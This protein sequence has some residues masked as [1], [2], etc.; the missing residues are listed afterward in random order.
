MNLSKGE[1]N[2]QL[3]QPLNTA[4][5]HMWKKLDPR[6]ASTCTT[7]WQLLPR[8]EWRATFFW[9]VLFHPF[10]T[11]ALRVKW[12]ENPSQSHPEFPHCCCADS[13]MEDAA[14]VPWAEAASLQGHE[15]KH[16]RVRI[17]SE[18]RARKKWILHIQHSQL[19]KSN[20]EQQQ[21]CH[22]LQVYCLFPT[23]RECFFLLLP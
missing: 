1:K 18:A 4:F 15:E 19:V 2:V 8:V 21:S 12:A 5:S 11:R 3:C 13:L 23:T 22:N 9:K 6:E 7:V 20:Y 10:S 14:V 17:T 16:G